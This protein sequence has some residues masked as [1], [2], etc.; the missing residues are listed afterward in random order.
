M[1]KDGNGMDTNRTANGQAQKKRIR[2]LKESAAF[3][4]IF[5]TVLLL[6]VFS[7]VVCII[8]QLSF[9]DALLEQYADGAFMT[10][11]SAAQYLDTN[12][13][14]AYVLEGSGTVQYRI[15]R[16]HLEQLCNSSGA[17]FI[18]VIQPDLSDYAHIT[19]FF[20][21]INK[22]SPYTVYEYG[23]VRET[24][25][26]EYRE[27]Y[28]MLYEKKAQQELVIRDKGYIETD[29]HITAMI[30]LQD[31]KGEVQAILCVQR[32]MDALARVRREYLDRVLQVLIALVLLVIIGQSI[33]LHRTVLSPL[34]QITREAARFS[35]E[36]VTTGK[37]LRETIHN[38]DEIGQLAESVDRMEEQIQ[39]YVENLTRATAEKQR[40]R[41]E[42]ELAARIQAAMLPDTFPPFPDRTEFDLYAVMDPAR[43][44]GGDFYDFFLTDPDHLCL[45]IAD[46][47]GKGIPA[48]LFMMAS[49]ITLAYNA[50]AGKTPAQILTDTNSSICRNNREE[51]FVTVWL[52]ILE[53][54]TGR[55][56][57]ANAG[58][59]YPAVRVPGGDFEL[60]RDRHGFV[61][62]G[63]EGVKYQEYELQLT[64]GSQLFLYTD[65]LPEATDAG[66]AMFGT[67]RMLCALNEEQDA[68]PQRLLGNVRK[69]ADVFV[70]EAEQ[71]DD[72]TMLCVSYR[73]KEGSLHVASQSDH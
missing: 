63:M 24:T 42:L 31:Q 66:G 7:V 69:A 73:G 37:K 51:M 21:V 20:S 28:R 3:R 56:T 52:G 62:G 36:N 22:D 2:R 26:E 40:I 33:F 64:P 19:F 6:V 23:Y 38:R 70:K 65:G 72:L 49:M 57:A 46:V 10:A 1:S 67:Q 54:S 5:G 17:T 12:N 45:M 30:P 18:Y 9:T 16:K 27:K 15:A 13:I 53:I 48:A 41:T 11:R 29:P 32:Q 71:F 47:S 8:G 4:S 68:S 35:A 61:I 44:V 25:N 50:M 43:E 58:H 55:L 39:D 14:D 60:Y 34:K 59:E